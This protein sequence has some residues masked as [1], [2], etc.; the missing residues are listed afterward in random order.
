MISIDVNRLNIPIINL[1]IGMIEFEG[2]NE[3]RISS[4]SETVRYSWLYVI[5]TN[6]ENANDCKDLEYKEAK[7]DSEI[8]F[9]YY[10]N[11]ITNHTTWTPPEDWNYM[12]RHT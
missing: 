11:Q 10:L 3:W 9:C 4:H 7:G 12:V 8:P 6:Y 1:R 2:S 5:I